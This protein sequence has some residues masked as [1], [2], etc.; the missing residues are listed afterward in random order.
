MCFL[1]IYYFNYYVTYQLNYC[2]TGCGHCKNLKP[3]WDKAATQ[4]K[5]EEIDGKLAALDATK[6]PKIA[7]D[8]K[9][10]KFDVL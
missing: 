8:F 4:M 1:S 9:V 10:C 5:E 3:E 6:Y 7:N 2:V